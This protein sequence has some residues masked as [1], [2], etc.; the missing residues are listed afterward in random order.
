MKTFLE[1]LPCFVNQAL[2][3]LKRANSTPEQTEKVMRA[4]FTELAALDF[5]ASPPVTGTKIYRIIRTMVRSADPFAHDKKQYNAL[6][7]SLVPEMQQ[8]ITQAPD[9]FLA[10]L[11]LAIAA[12]IIDFG[13]NGSLSESEVRAC[14]DRASDARI[15]EDAALRL[16]HAV[17][18]AQSVLYLCD[19]AGEIVFDR[20]LI[21]HLP[22]SKITCAVR[23]APAINDATMEDANE[24]GLTE[25]VSVISNGS[26]APGTILADCSEEFHRAFDAADLVIA[27]GQGNFE[28]LSDVHDKR[29][30]FL[31]QIKCP[32]IARDSGFP[33]GTFVVSERY[34]D[35]KIETVRPGETVTREVANG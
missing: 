18:E 8:V 14:L 11:K 3:S 2:S 24:A 6:A 13:K 25:L 5:S 12:N 30:F 7:L 34:V 19:N 1:C 23:G 28:T 20:L 17:V 31:L 27:K 16:Q 4:V 10:A 26:D 22:H 29:L 33:T 32:V 9:P 35:C 15:D 21:E